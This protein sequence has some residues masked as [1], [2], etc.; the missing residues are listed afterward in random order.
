MKIIYQDNPLS[1]IIELTESEKRE[2]WLKIK[3]SELEYL[4]ESAWF[5]ATNKK[6]DIEAIKN[7]LDIDYWC[8]DDEKSKLDNRVDEMFDWYLDDL[9]GIHCGD[10]TCV[11]SSCSKCHVEQLL[12]IDTIEG[13]PKHSASSIEYAFREFKT[14]DE[15]I[16]S[17]ENYVPDKSKGGWNTE[18][19]ERW[20]HF[21]PI[22]IK[23]AN[24]AAAWLKHYK[25]EK[26]LDK[27]D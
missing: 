10:C 6:P 20:N 4:L 9:K 16:E 22:F 7:D 1:T 12:G 13:L 2:L 26:L 24:E 25:S 21:V 18:S 23:H 5:E 27:I 17:L 3:I 14:I 11:P 15:A 8:S 19:D